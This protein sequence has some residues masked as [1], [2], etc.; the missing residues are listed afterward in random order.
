MPVNYVFF[1]DI[2][3]GR[4]FQ[5]PT[6]I[7]YQKISIEQAIPLLTSDKKAITNGKISTLFVNSKIQLV[8]VP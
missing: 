8:I 6:K 5:L 7:T 2:P 3:I 4:K 1:N